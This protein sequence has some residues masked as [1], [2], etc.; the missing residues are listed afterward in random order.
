MGVQSLWLLFRNKIKSFANGLVLSL[1]VFSHTLGL[2]PC[3][4]A[5]YQEEVMNVGEKNDFWFVGND[6]RVDS[7]GLV[8]RKSSCFYIRVSSRSW[9][10]YDGEWFDY[11]ALFFAGDVTSN[12]DVYSPNQVQVFDTQNNLIVSH[13]VLG[14]VSG[15]FTET[16]SIPNGFE[17]S[18]YRIKVIRDGEWILIT[19]V[20]VNWC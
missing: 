9:S 6:W 16:I 12:C 3:V 18:S 19:E 7:K 17:D 5:I 13:N 11:A 4:W 2:R 10:H 20:S 8:L 1:E 15:V 14:E